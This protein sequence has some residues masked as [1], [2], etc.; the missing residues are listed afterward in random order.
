VQ[1]DDEKDS[2]SGIEQRLTDCGGVIRDNQAN[3]DGEADEDA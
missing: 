3:G 1:C 2:P